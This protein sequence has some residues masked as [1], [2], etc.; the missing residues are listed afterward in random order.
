LAVP[1]RE[2]RLLFQKSGNR[3]AFSDCRRL[4]TASSDFDGDV[5]LGEAAHIVAERANGP[6]GESCLSTAER[7]RYDNLI[8][9]CNTHHQLIDSAPQTYTVER[10]RAIKRDHEAWVE[11]RLSIPE[12]LRVPMV[13]ETLYGTFLPVVHV[14]RLVYGFPCA[15]SDERMLGPFLQPGRAGEA[16][17]FIIRSGNLLAFQ[18]MS[19]P[20]NPFAALAKGKP[21]ERFIVEK[22]LDHPQYLG[23]FSTLLN[24][25]LNKLTG[26]RGLHL[27]KEHRRY[28]FPMLVEGQNRREQYL[29]M[30]GRKVK[31]NVVWKTVSKKTGEP[32]GPW[33]HRAI[34]LRFLRVDR[35]RWCLNLRPELRI[36]T[37]GETPL[38]SEAIGPHATRRASRVFNHDLFKEVHFWRDYLGGST[39]ALKVDFHDRGQFLKISTTLATGTISW[40]GTPPQ[41]AQ[42]FT[43]IEY[44]DD[45]DSWAQLPDSEKLDDDEDAWE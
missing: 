34:S 41:Y 25:S 11:S 21:V 35:L 1:Y 36:T 22:W 6:R 33:Y 3:C 26:R 2:L 20:G 12:Q 30:T 17:P 23:W 8:L 39:G 10:L 32:Y 9:L 16:A 43:N 15:E 7:N 19:E 29:S 45:D 40:P 18:N 31:R 37:D 4:L 13:E 38:S 28:Y 14:P 44:L 5:V 42:K 24:R 27:D